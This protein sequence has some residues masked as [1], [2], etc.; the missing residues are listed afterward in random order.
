[1]SPSR[2]GGLL[3][4]IDDLTLTQVIENFYD[5]ML[6]DQRLAQF[7]SDVNVAK[8]R[9]HQR[10]FLLAALSGPELFNDL[11]L[12]AAH[13]PLGL[14]HNDF[15]RAI[16]H[17]T[18]AMADAGVPDDAVAPIRERLEPLRVHITAASRRG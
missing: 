7:F 11:T 12:A 16:G 6:A 1:M 2:R 3:D 15:D 14:T 10:S 17:L 18:A 5:R 13:L 9:A 8:L 4:A